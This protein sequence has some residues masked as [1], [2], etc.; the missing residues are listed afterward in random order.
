MASTLH[1]S[2]VRE[3][4]LLDIVDDEWAADTLSDDGERRALPRAASAP[5]RSPPRSAAA[6][7]P[8]RRRAPARGSHASQRG[9]GRAGLQGQ[10][11]REVDGAG[12]Q[13]GA[14]GGA[15][16]PR[17]RAPEGPRCSRLP[18]AEMGSSAGGQEGSPPGTARCLG[19]A[20]LAGSST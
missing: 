11:G 7:P 3:P 17:G 6:R 20:G 15:P 1:P 14:L 16:Q 5:G 13:H 10:R 8:A 4:E 2:L 19:A 12:A 18:C 9:D